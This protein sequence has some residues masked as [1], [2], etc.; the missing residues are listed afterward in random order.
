MGRDT[1]KKVTRFGIDK[2]RTEA[3]ASFLL[4]TPQTIDVAGESEI[5]EHP[6][7]GWLVDEGAALHR[8]LCYVERFFEVSTTSSQERCLYSTCA[9]LESTIIKQLERDAE[10]AYL[11][12]SEQ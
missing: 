10:C 3:A 12:C 5:R 9:A 11:R 1:R 8:R 7:A 2:I 4:I 6:P